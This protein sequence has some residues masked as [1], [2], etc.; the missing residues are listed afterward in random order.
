M[1]TTGCVLGLNFAVLGAVAD[2]S[3]TESAATEL[4]EPSQDEVAEVS[5][6]ESDSE[7]AEAQAGNTPS[8]QQIAA[9]PSQQAEDL[10]PAGPILS[11]E[12][13]EDPGQDQSGAVS[14]FYYYDITDVAAE[15]IVAQTNANLLK[16]WTAT[17]ASGWQHS[18]KVDTASRVVVLFS[19]LS[20]GDEVEFEVIRDDSGL[21]AATQKTLE[22]S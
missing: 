5:L 10:S 9:A 6:V 11:L 22:T 19:P 21:I 17:D 7:V 1:I 2:P 13:L 3:I 12:G 18:V 8:P 20:G 4:E 16:F 14:E 15:I